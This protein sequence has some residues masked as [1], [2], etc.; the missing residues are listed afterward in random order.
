M[1]S[2]MRDLLLKHNKHWSGTGIE[3]GIKRE[4]TDLLL[5]AI[6]VNHIIAISGARRSG[7]SYLFRQLLS[8]LLK[9]SIPAANILFL[10]F[11]DPFFATQANN[12][13]ILDKIFTE[14]KVL[15]NPEGRTYLFFD[16]IQNIQNWQ[17][18]VRELYDRD[19]TVKIFITGSNSEMLSVDLATHLT[20]RVL[21]F[22]NFPFSFREFISGMESFLL[23]DNIDYESLFP[24]RETIMHL[25]ETRFEKGFFPETAYLESKELTY[26]VLSQYFQ[27]VIFKDIIPRFVIRNSKTIEQLAYYC[28]NT[29]AAKFS[30]RR[31]AEAVS[32]NENTI[33]EYLSYFEKAY[34]FFV[35]EHF[36]YSMR[37]QL[38]YAK[39]LYI[40]D[41]GLRNATTS[42]FSPDQGKHAENVVFTHLRKMSKNINF[43]ADEKSGKEIDFIVKKKDKYL[44]C[45]VSYTDELPEREFQAFPLFLK[46]SKMKNYECLV[47]SKGKFSTQIY[48]NITINTIPLWLF[49]LTLN[50]EDF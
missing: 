41:S 28:S 6:D 20:G 32:S 39:K 35:V 23:P 42:S 34:L 46:L 22:E 11:E 9:N 1:E 14:Y 45:N 26:D 29:F 16:E 27:N 25:I 44:L 15:K 31:L 38:K 30:Y 4:I 7:K 48:D 13:E 12:A 43:W 40:S 49:L 5:A 47:V 10:N 24:V 33:K 2:S 37:K 8:H 36:E 18:W 17:L 21:A 50:K 19:D 3:T